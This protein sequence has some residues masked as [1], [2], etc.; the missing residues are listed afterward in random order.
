MKCIIEATGKIVAVKIINLI[1]EDESSIINEINLLKSVNHPNI[2]K[3][4]GIYE[5]NKEVWIVMEYCLTNLSSFMKRIK[6]KQC[7]IFPK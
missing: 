7:E 2:I 5:L 3:Y 1:S 4:Y 6:G